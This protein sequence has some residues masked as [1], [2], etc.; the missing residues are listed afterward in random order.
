MFVDKL[1]ETL[2]GNPTDDLTEQDEI[3]VA[4]TK[5]DSRGIGGDS[6]QAS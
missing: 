3:D 5:A 4:V 6:A 1:I 2:L